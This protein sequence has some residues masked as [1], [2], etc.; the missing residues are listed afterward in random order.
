MSQAALVAVIV[1][2]YN[3]AAYLAQTLDSILG[4]SF[5]HFTLFVVD[6]AS[7][8]ATP[9]II[10]DYARKDSRIRS[11]INGQNRGIAASH[12]AAMALCDAPYIA[13]MGADDLVTADWLEKNTL[14]WK[15]SPLSRP[16]AV[17]CKP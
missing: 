2:V 9:A 13:P 8:D 10:A 6:D 7:T 4:Q 11:I 12:N 3:G 15:L 16:L 5:P 14:P 1:S 17:P